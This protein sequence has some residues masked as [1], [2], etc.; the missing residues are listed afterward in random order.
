MYGV[1]RLDVFENITLASFP[2][3]PL[4]VDISSQIFTDFAEA[5]IIIDMISQSAPT[6]NQTAVSFTCEDAD[7]VKVLECVE[8]MNKKNPIVTP[9]VSSGNCKIKLFGPDMPK[10]AGIYAR[11]MR[12]LAGTGVELML[13]STSEVDISLLVRQSHLA[14]AQAALQKAFEL[15]A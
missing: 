10:F 13:V 9:M 3:I 4:D 12:G 7:M 15:D 6:K 2:Q 8:K 5:G 1:T 14:D 11:A